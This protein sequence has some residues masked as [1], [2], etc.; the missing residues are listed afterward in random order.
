MTAICLFTRDLRLADN[1]AL[2]HALAA[3]DEVVPLFVIDDDLIA[4]PPVSANRIGFLVEALQDLRSGLRAIGADLVVRRG[5]SRRGF[6]MREPLVRRA[7]T[8]RMTCRIDGTAT[9]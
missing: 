9:C 2:A 6:G 8:I 7:Q 5:R 4:A 1:P 3:A